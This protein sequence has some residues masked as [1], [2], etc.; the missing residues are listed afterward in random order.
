[1]LKNYSWSTD[2][3]LLIL[4]LGVGAIFIT[5]GYMKMF[6]G[7]PSGAHFIL[8][9]GTVGFFASLGFSAFWAY[10]VTAVEFLGGVS[11]LF[12]IYNRVSAALLA[13]VMAAADSLVHKM[14]GCRKCADSSAAGK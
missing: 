6:N 2:V 11:V 1:M 4:R 13:V 14:C 12:G 3:G 5:T 8:T 9:T 7:T 10:L